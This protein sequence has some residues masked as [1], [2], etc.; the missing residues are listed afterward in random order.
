MAEIFHKFSV[1]QETLQEVSPEI[2]PLK[3]KI[4][5]E[6]LNTNLQNM[7]IQAISS[8]RDVLERFDDITEPIKKEIQ[9]RRFN[10]AHNL[11]QLTISNLYNSIE[12]YNREINSIYEK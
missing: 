7:I 8:Q 10:E 11:V 2:S 6:F 3:K 12:D 9:V 4:T 1:F 5:Y